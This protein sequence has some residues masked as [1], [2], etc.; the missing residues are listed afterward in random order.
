MLKNPRIRR[1]V[2]LG[3]LA[4]GGV[5]FLLAPENAW[6]GLIFAGLGVLLEVLG[7]ALRH[8]GRS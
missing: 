7:I 4:T 8:A 2:S 6:I 3:L 1:R 5:L